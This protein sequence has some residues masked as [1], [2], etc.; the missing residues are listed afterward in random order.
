MRN[1]LPILS[2]LFSLHSSAQITGAD[3]VCAGYIYSYSVAIP[4]AATFNWTVPAGWYGLTGQ[5]TSQISVTCNL[6][7]GQICAEGFDSIGASVGT[8]CL[9]TT[10]GGGAGSN[11][12]LSPSGYN[13]VCQ[14]TNFV[15]ITPQLIYDGP[16][17]SCPNGC[18]GGQPHP[19]IF[20]A[21]YSANNYV[22]PI[23][24]TI[25]VGMGTFYPAYVDTTLGSDFP[26]AIE[27]SSNCGGAV[28][29]TFSFNQVM[30]WPP[31]VTQSPSPVCVGDTVTLTSSAFPCSD[32]LFVGYWGGF[33]N[34]TPISSIYVS[35]QLQLIVTGINSTVYNGQCVGLVGMFDFQSCWSGT[36]YT[37]S[38]QTCPAD[39][40]FNSSDT[41]IC[42]SSCIDFS[43]FSEHAGSY[44]WLFPG[45]VPSASVDTNPSAICYNTPGSYDVTLIAVGSFGNDTLTLSNF[46]QVS[47][48]PAPQ[49]ITQHDDTLYANPGAASY[50][51]YYN[52]N[53]IPGATDYFWVAQS[54][55][56]YNVIASDSIGCEVE[57]AIFNV[58]T[59]AQFEVPGL[60]FEVYPNP[61]A[62]K[63]QIKNEKLRMEAV[64]ISIYTV[65][66]EKINAAV[67]RGL[68]A[69]D[70]RLLPPGI[71]FIEILTWDHKTVRGR[72]VK[73]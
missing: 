33:N 65:I 59:S 2:F 23:G 17:G 71:Y 57:A 51:W 31:S 67:D 37:I 58:L 14:T 4:G 42:A 46:I 56:D 48:Q 54:N 21:L 9:T 16:G 12:H 18:G 43:N 36:T 10:M 3:T 41:L 62:E 8:F 72:F 66:G 19:N 73:K 24:T 68:L 55:G 29:G 60:E 50:Q 45:G 44:Q 1:I 47:P 40:I 32:G 11:Y 15:S 69:A 27:I 49:G 63:L 61:V 25:S 26:Q 20:W 6:S 70:C 52:G 35:N 28:T 13:S 38:V 39:A 34:N 53:L 30:L 22:G 5:G 7:G 64:E